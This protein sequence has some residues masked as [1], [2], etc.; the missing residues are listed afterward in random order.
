MHHALEPLSYVHSAAPVSL[1]VCLVLAG[2]GV[3]PR[4]LPHALVIGTV[5]AAAAAATAATAAASGWRRTESPRRGEAA[6]L[7]V[8]SAARR[9]GPVVCV[10]AEGTVLVDAVALEEPAAPLAKV[11][12]P[13]EPAEHAVPVRLMV[14][15]QPEVA[16]CRPRRRE[17]ARAA[18][19]AG[20]PQSLG[21]WASG[22]GWGC[23]KGTCNG[24]APIYC[25]GRRAIWPGVL[26]TS[27]EDETPR[28]RQLS[29]LLSGHQLTH[30]SA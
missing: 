7:R 19:R 3:D 10:G 30:A 21:G 29:R 8:R 26:P 17:A 25:V 11:H 28:V 18:W 27:T 12:V 16:L 2:E 24:D 5:V 15:P 20:Q 14:P 13:V 6:A 22:A 23:S 9:G 4:P 1:Q